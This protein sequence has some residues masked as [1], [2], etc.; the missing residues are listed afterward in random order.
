MTFTKRPAGHTALSVGIL[1]AGL[2]LLLPIR[3][4]PD[5][6]INDAMALTCYVQQEARCCWLEGSYPTYWWMCMENHSP[7]PV[8]PEG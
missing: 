3:L 5:L 4:A 2:A 8:D 7:T 1:L 6:A